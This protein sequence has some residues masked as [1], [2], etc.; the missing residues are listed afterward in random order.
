MKSVKAAAEPKNQH[1]TNLKTTK[2]LFSVD[3]HRNKMT[4]IFQRLIYKWKESDR[5][6]EIFDSTVH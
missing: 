4:K 2:V 3:N 5:I 1:T 6:K